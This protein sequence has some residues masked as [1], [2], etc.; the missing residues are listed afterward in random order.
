MRTLRFAVEQ[1]I[2]MHAGYHV[3]RENNSILEVF[4][5]GVHAL[6]ATLEKRLFE[7]DLSGIRYTAP[8]HRKKGG[9]SR[10]ICAED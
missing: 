1:E 10:P 9:V 2:E 6:N 7:M 5:E 3:Y 4:Q 8:T